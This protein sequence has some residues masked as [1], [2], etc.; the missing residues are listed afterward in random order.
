MIAIVPYKESWS[1]DFKRIGGEIKI[2]LR[3]LALA[4]HHIGSTSVQ[5]LSAKDIIDI[6]VTVKTF[7]H[8]IE[9][10]LLKIGFQRLK[11]ITADHR[12]PGRSDI[13]ASELQKQFYQRQSPDINLHVRIAGTYNQRYPLL[14][15]DY[16]RQH[17]N[18]A[19]AYE[20]VKINLAKRFP[21]NLEAY[22][23]IKDPV[24]DV[25]M[26][27]AEAWADRTTWIAAPSDI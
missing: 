25:I 8:A 1:I 12:P 13:T 17:H 27:G 18:A 14:C 15:R 10:R 22:Y 2:T 20:L 21:N 19:L 5:G 16:L 11:T 26:A 23:E 6:Q 9:D 4:I 7:D 24:F 3:D